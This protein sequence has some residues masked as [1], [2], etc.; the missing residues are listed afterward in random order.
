MKKEPDV[1]VGLDLGT[2]KVSVVVAERDVRYDEAQIIGIGQAPSAG[3]RKGMIVNLEQAVLSVRRAVREA[4]TMVGFPLDEVT[5]AFS[6]VEIDSVM[7]HGMVSLG[8]TPRQIEIDDIERVIE[9]AQSELSVASNR[10]VLHT[11][12]VKYSIDGNSGIDDPLGM[13]GIRLEIELQSVVVPTT[14]LQNV[15]NCVERAGVSVSGLVVKPL[16]AALGALSAEERTAGAVVISIGGGTTG[17]A[18]FVDGRP[19]KLSVI[20]I[21]GDHIT[22]DLAYVAKIPISVAEELKKKLSLEPDTGED[23]FEVV[24]R[25]KSKVMPVD[26]LSDVVSCRLEELFS[27][28]VKG[29]L[30]GVNYHAFPS[31]IILTGGVALMEGLEGFVS[32]IMGLPVR[33]GIPVV[34]HQMPPGLGTCQHAALAGIVRYLVEKDRHQY[35]YI[36]TPVH[37]LRGGGYGAIREKTTKRLPILG[38]TNGIFDSIK[39]AFKDLF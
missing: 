19:V 26:A 22:N 33:I 3:I 2:S 36:E 18:L 37:V 39:Q 9:T 15:M 32:E 4:E 27:H 34:S 12:P 14:A 16:V 11:I 28:H 10:S 20:P 23:E 17:A 8:R 30:E 29:L 7:S 21:G 1:F 31:G 25:G 5:V 24:I 35:R 13:T 6:G 38:D